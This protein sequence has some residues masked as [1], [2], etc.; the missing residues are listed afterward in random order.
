M[1]VYSKN[2]IGDFKIEPY[3]ISKS[4]AAFAATP[5][6]HLNTVGARLLYDN[7]YWKAGAEYAHEFGKYTNGTKRIAN[8]GYVFAGYN[9]KETPL[10]PEAE[11]RY[12][13][14][15]GDDKNT[16]TNETWDPLFSRAPYWN[17]LFVY[18]LIPETSKYSNGVPGYWTNL[19]IY[20]ASVKLNFLKNAKLDYL[21]D[22][23]L[24]LAWEYLTAPQATAGLSAAMFTN[25]G[26]NIGNLPT[27]LLYF[28]C[29]KN[30]DG[31]VQWEYLLP[32][33]FY[34]TTAKN[35]SFFRWQLQFKI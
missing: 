20:K 24:T 8:G 21:S 9:F 33:N 15:S 30:I 5:R 10:S 28:K 3:Y 16:S 32:G 23:N 7:T 11:L 35:A 17:E 4:E 26:T 29:N 25:S 27:T 22:L 2:N 13:Y 18:T 12:V 31:F 1:L 6:L 34:T 14:L 19:N